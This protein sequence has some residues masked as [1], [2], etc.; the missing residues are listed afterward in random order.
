VLLSLLYARLL[1]SQDSYSCSNGNGNE[2]MTS[3]HSHSHTHSHTSSPL[4][5][6]LESA[7]HPA[8]NQSTAVHDTA[9]A[10]TSTPPKSS[11]STTTATQP[12]PIAFSSSASNSPQLPAIS[13]ITLPTSLSGGKSPFKRTAQERDDLND[14]NYLTDTLIVTSEAEFENA[15]QQFPQYL[16]FKPAFALVL[17]Q[18]QARV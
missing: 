17:N 2:L 10:M 7:S 13:N 5:S 6:T 8:Q 1:H 3:P 11:T 16:H 9:S 4:P 18:K 15:V 14:N 12:K